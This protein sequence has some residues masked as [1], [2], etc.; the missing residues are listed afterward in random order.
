MQTV[1]VDY[2][3]LDEA[4]AA[5]GGLRRVY[6]AAVR[7]TYANARRVDGSILRQKELR[8]L[9]K[10]R[11]AHLGI[12]DAWLLHCATL[13][14]MDLSKLRPDGDLVFGGKPQP[15]RRCK[16]LVSREAWRRSRLRPLCSR[17]DRT[18]TGNRYFRLAPDAATCTLSVHGRPVMPR[19]ASM[20]GKAGEILWQV[21]RLAAGKAI[22]LTL[23]P[24]DK[25]L[26]VTFDPVDLPGH[27][28]R[29]TPVEAV[30]GRGWSPGRSR[31]PGRPQTV[32]CRARSWHAVPRRDPDGQQTR[33]HPGRG[34]SAPARPTGR[35]LL[36]RRAPE[37]RA[38][39]LAADHFRVGGMAALAVY[40]IRSRTATPFVEY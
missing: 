2:T 30:P 24:D 7:T 32:R 25:H 39:G 10:A 14:G 34:G 36:H 31:D 38:E 8:D 18:Q 26:H 16:G 19:L 5:I 35:A 29:L 21:A 11:F 1:S 4:R 27:P 33:R 23:R 9:V 6:A 20:R 22:N 28:E 37:L 3:C 13:E 17:G 12:A 15:E 40:E